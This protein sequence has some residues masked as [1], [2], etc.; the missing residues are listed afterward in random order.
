MVEL[1]P[2]SGIYLYQD[3]LNE[4]PRRKS[5]TACAAYLLNVF[6]TNA[7]LAGRNLTGASGKESVDEDIVKSIISKFITV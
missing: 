7:E 3:Q 2:G 5:A 6:Y 1:T 4:A